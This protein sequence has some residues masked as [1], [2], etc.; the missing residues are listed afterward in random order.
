[1]AQILEDDGTPYPVTVDVVIAGGGAA[2]LVTALAAGDRRAGVLVIQRDAVPR[3][4]TSLSA[5]LIPAAETRYQRALGIQDRP[6]MFAADILRKAHGEPAPDQ[7]ELLASTIGP[8][9]EWRG[10]RRPDSLSGLS[11]ISL[12]RDIPPCACTACRPARAPGLWI[13]CAPQPRLRG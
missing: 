7:V 5:G 1:M 8:A 12:P 10:A 9:I 2:G 4:S 3:G 13:G 6:E 11:T